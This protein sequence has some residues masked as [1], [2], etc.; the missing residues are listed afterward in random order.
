MGSCVDAAYCGV[1]CIILYVGQLY[2]E[3]KSVPPLLSSL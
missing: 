2:C 1:Q 3:I